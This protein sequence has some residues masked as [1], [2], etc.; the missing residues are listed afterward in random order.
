LNAAGSKN[1]E[2]LMFCTKTL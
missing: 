1:F 2:P